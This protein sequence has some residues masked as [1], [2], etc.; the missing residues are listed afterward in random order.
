MKK[1]AAIWC[2]LGGAL[3]C[4]GGRE[5]PACDPAAP[6]CGSD[7]VCLLDRAEGEYRCVASC[8]PARAD[9]CPGVLACEPIAGQGD[10]AACVTRAFITGRVIDLASGQPVSGAL[11]MARKTMDGSVTDVAGTGDDGSFRVEV[12]VVRD[13]NG[14]PK[15]G[16]VHV[17]HVSASDYLP[18]P[19]PLRPAIPIAPTQFEPEIP[20]DPDSAWIFTS[21]LAEV[22]LVPLPDSAKGR[23]SLRGSLVDPAG[24]VLVVAECPDPP[25]PY[26]YTDRRGAFTIFNVAAGTYRLAAYRKGTYHEAREVVVGSSDL[27]DLSL[28]TSAFSGGS[29]TGSVNIVNAP[30]GSRTSVVLVPESTF[31][32]GLRIGVM[33]PGLRAPDP[34]ADPDVTGAFAITGIP[35]GRYV[36]FA[37]FENDGL[38]LDPDPNI[39]G[40]QVV[41]VEVT[42]AAPT[43]TLDPFKVT[44]AL[45]VVFPGAEGPQAV[46]PPVT[47]I[48]GDDSSEDAYTVEVFDVHGNLL[49][50]TKHGEVTG[51]AEVSVP[52]EGPTLEAGTFYHWRATS[53]RKDGPISSTEDLRGVFYVEP[54]PAGGI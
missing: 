47:F 5:V 8:D 9:A 44:E 22:G 23:P 2:V 16:D 25:C 39:A 24:G 40:T 11:V 21:P 1:V 42:A 49:W 51:S 14:K 53:Y 7:G 19:T 43:R 41:H 38:V 13:S 12:R 17:L 33:A 34:P 36:V 32:K 20:D 27:D 10:K 48:F 4:G 37:A 28:A 31:H 30:G 35:E 50:E 52:Y 3:A 45:P 6:D 26:G 54:A 18:Y 29:V 46:T 15:T